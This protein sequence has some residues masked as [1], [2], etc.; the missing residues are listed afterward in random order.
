MTSRFVSVVADNRAT[1]RA[2]AAGVAVE[3][4]PHSDEGNHFVGLAA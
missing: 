2:R 3:Q 1:C 4:Q